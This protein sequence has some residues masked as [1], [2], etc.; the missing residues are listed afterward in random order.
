MCVCVC[1]Y[2]SGQ[3][4][5][6]SAHTNTF[7][8]PL[9]HTITSGSGKVYGAR[10]TIQVLKLT[11]CF[12]WWWCTRVGILSSYEPYNSTHHSHMMLICCSKEAPLNNWDARLHARR[13]CA[14]TYTRTHE[15]GLREFCLQPSILRRFYKSFQKEA[16]SYSKGLTSRVGVCIIF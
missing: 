4:V 6:P 9:L 10:K 16:F 8:R 14:Q 15:R 2:G 13:L 7:T 1:V 5:Q 12:V 3:Y 11:R